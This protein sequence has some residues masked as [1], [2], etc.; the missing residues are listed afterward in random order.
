MAIPRLRPEDVRA[1]KNLPA[2]GE[3]AAN[4]ARFNLRLRDYP[5]LGE[6]ETG[7]STTAGLPPAGVTYGNSREDMQPT[8]GFARRQRVARP[9]DFLE[10]RVE[11]DLTRPVV[12]HNGGVRSTLIGAGRGFLRG[13]ARTGSLAGG[14]GGA[15]SGAITHGLDHSLDERYA[16][17]ELTQDDA[18]AYGAARGIEAAGLKAEGARSDVRYK[19]AAAGYAEARPEIEAAKIAETHRKAE[20]ARIFR[21]LTSLRGQRLDPSNPRHAKLIADADAAGIPLDAESFNNSR[22]NLVRYVKADPD[23]PEK[24]IEVERNMVTGQETVLGQKGFQATRGADGRTTAEVKSDEDRD[25]GFKALE[26]ERN[27]SNELRRASLNLSGQRFDLSKAQYDNRLS[28]D[29]RKELKSANDLIAEAERYQEDA[30]SVGARTKYIDPDTGKEMESAKRQIKRDEY[31]ARAA[32]LRRR[33]IANYGYLFAD[34]D[35]ISTEQFRQLFPSLGGNFSGEAQRLGLTLT[36]D[37]MQG[38]VGR[39]AVPRRGAPAAARSAGRSAS[40]VGGSGRPSAPSTDKTHVSRAKARQ[41]YPELRGK[42][43]AEIDEAIKAQGL[44]PMP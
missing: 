17:N 31:Q 30:N 28:E 34:G 25:R 20:E 41:T 18:S 22:G 3:E 43:D 13:V 4:D 32:A 2:P 16:A 19:N 8:E 12:D 37:P 33:A 21:A 1:S 36:D 26:R 15:A 9:I 5:G 29:T 35:K 11:E 7:A 14:V 39:S 6:P 40:P 23:S 42:S 24:T 44:I 27:I 10:H 38:P